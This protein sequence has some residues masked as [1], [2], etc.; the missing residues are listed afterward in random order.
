[1]SQKKPISSPPT[2]RDRRWCMVKGGPNL[3]RARTGARKTRHWDSPGRPLP[4]SPGGPPGQWCRQPDPIPDGESTVPV[5]HLS[6][7]RW[8]DAYRRRGVSE[9]SVPD[10]RRTVS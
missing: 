3:L 5:P 2:R 10:G 9:I 6:G 4:R 1:M 7:T 8:S